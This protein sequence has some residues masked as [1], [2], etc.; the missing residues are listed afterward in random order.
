MSDNDLPRPQ[1]DLWQPQH[2]D[3]EPDQSET[4]QADPVLEVEELDDEE[5]DL[6]PG[7]VPV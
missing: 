1:A 2:S 6:G 5:T 4:A 7:W 3:P